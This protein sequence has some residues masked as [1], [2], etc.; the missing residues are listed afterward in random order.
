MPWFE[1][2]GRKRKKAYG[3]GGGVD[4]GYKG[5]RKST[6]PLFKKKT[7]K[8]DKIVKN[9]HFRALEMDQKETTN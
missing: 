2:P 9:N 6:S 8:L 3:D 4:S 5:T 1:E 7:V